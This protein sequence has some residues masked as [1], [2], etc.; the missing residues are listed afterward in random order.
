MADEFINLSELGERARPANTDLLHLRSGSGIDSKVLFENLY[1]EIFDRVNPVGVIYTQLPNKPSPIT[2][3]W[4]G[5]WVN[6]SSEF[7]GD[8]FRVE[9][10]NASVFQS[11][12][13]LEATNLK[14]H[15]HPF[16]ANPHSHTTAVDRVGDAGGV[17]LYG[18]EFR[19][20]Q[21][22]NSSFNSNSVTVTGTIGNPS[23]S[24]AETRPVNRTVRIWERTA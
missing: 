4:R 21:L 1:N 17:P 12:Q 6:I 15:N 18:L 9:G 14:N 19:P 24:D 5:T 7:P 8:F 10:G 3:G 23:I 22:V 11:G 20:D 13:Q 16:T 2:L